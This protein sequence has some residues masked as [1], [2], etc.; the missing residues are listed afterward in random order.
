MPLAAPTDVGTLLKAFDAV[1]E[2][3][4]ASF[5]PTSARVRPISSNNDP[6]SA[7]LGPELTNIVPHSAEPS[8]T[9]TTRPG[10]DR[11]WPGVPILAGL[12]GLWP[13]CRPNFQR[14]HA[15]DLRANPRRP[16]DRPLHYVAQLAFRDGHDSASL[17]G[18]NL[19]TGPGLVEIG[20]TSVVSGPNVVEGR[21]ILTSCGAMLVNPGPSLADSGSNFA[22]IGRVRAD[23]G[24]NGATFHSIVSNAATSVPNSVGVFQ[25]VPARWT[26]LSPGFGLLAVS[27]NLHAQ[28]N[29][30][31]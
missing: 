30:V 7:K 21:L 18:P 12:S 29:Y 4:G 9:S 20:P 17:D 1:D 6:E 16:L 23:G 5:R 15:P 19:D 2:K 24:R 31:A 13:G 22:E 28:L 10:N 14:T 26:V 27:S 3:R 25:F 11:F 8:R